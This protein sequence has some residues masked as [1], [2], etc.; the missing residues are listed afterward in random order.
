MWRKIQVPSGP[1]RVSRVNPGLAPQRKPAIRVWAGPGRA[2]PI[3]AP[4]P[5]Q[6]LPYPTLPRRSAPTCQDLGP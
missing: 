3:L 6:L 2:E 4:T 1:M 5:N